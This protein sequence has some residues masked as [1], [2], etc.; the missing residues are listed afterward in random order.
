MVLSGKCYHG[1][2]YQMPQRRV[3]NVDRG[4]EVAKQTKMRTQSLK[5][6]RE[7]WEQMLR[8]KESFDYLGN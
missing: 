4:I 8:G 7:Q 2:K 6:H 1:R 3:W 5:E